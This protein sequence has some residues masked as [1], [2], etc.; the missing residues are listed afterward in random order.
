MPDDR[1]APWKYIPKIG[2]KLQIAFDNP[3]ELTH[4]I[5]KQREMRTQE[6]S[7]PERVQAYHA[8]L[9]AIVEHAIDSLGSKVAKL[10]DK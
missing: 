6:T 8:D 2:A 5:Q 1:K 3:T 4:A 10:S 7:D 9:T